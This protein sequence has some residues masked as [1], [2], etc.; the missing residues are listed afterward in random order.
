MDSQEAVSH[1]C[2]LVTPDEAYDIINNN[3]CNS[4]NNNS[5]D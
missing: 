1:H 4:N 5:D 3:D 2:Q